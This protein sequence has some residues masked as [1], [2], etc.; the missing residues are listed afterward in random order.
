MAQIARI[1]YGPG[2]YDPAHPTGNVLSQET[3]EVPDDPVATSR[4]AFVAAVTAA[5]S[6]ADL[7][8]LLI[9]HAPNIYTG[10]R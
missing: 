7:K 1:V 2:G 9:E 6:L 10:G 8:A 4:A 3:V 5:Q